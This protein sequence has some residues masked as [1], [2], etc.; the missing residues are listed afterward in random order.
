MK[1]GIDCKAVFKRRMWVM[2]W[3]LIEE[4]GRRRHAPTLNELGQGLE[5]ENPLM[6]TGPAHSL[7]SFKTCSQQWK[8]IGWWRHL[9]RIVISLLF[10]SSVVALTLFN[11]FALTNCN[12]FDNLFDVVSCILGHYTR[13]SGFDLRTCACVQN[14]GVSKVIMRGFW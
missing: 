1:K 3:R 10:R 4:N 5:E 12:R 7:L 8:H 2:K 11:F 14:V 9:R 13:G 6:Q